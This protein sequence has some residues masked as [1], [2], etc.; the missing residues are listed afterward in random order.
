MI[1]ASFLAVIG[2]SIIGLI[3]FGGGQIFMPLFQSFW[4]LLANKFN[5]NIDQ[6]KIDAIFTI[7]NATP[8]VVSTKFAAFTGLLI[9]NNEWWGW[10]L[11]LFTYLVFCL[12]AI[13]LMILAT[14]MVNKTEQTKYLKKL[15]T[16]FKPILA[17][18]MISLAIQ[19]L[20][21]SMFPNLI[22]NG[23][24]AYLT[25]AN[26]SKS[27]FFSGWR[28]WVLIIWVPLFA[29]ISMILYNKKISLFWIFLG[30]I[31]FSFILFQPW[32]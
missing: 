9:A 29:I 12:P 27:A 20:L 16:I 17:A 2:V 15:T 32:L 13:F 3:V 28:Y 21:A 6:A 24:D 31:I 22:F 7:S 8:G 10:I 26:N 11:A 30:G 4:L 25:F 5:L 23:K 19:L 18:I 1:L 14:K